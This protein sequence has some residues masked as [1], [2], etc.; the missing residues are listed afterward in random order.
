MKT[1]SI[2][3]VLALSLVALERATAQIYDTN[4]EV[5]QTF[6][7]SGF[8]GYLDGNGSVLSIYTKSFLQVVK[9]AGNARSCTNL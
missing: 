4:D 1:T 8:Y 7:G 3:L 2:S 5:V 6:V 9:P